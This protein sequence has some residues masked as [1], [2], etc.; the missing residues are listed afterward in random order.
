MTPDKNKIAADCLKRGTE[1][2]AREQFDYAVEMFTQSMK[3][4]PDN[5]L[6]RQSLRG[7][8]KK[9]YKENGSGARMAGMKLMKTRT[10]LKKSQMT[11]DW[12]GVDAVAEEGLKIN[13]W[14]SALN[15]AVGEACQNLGFNNVALFGYECALEADPKNKDLLRTYARMQEERGNYPTAIAAWQ[16]LLKIDELDSE[17]RSK[18][19]QLAA[20]SMMK[21]G[22]YEDAQ[23]TQDVKTGYD[24]DRPG[25]KG[26]K[27]AGEEV[28]DGPGMSLEADLERAVRKEPENKDNYL[29]LA[30]FLKRENRLEEA[31]ENLKKALDLTGGSDNTIREQLED[32][33]LDQLRNNQH[34]AREA[35][36]ADPNDE[37]ARKNS[38]ALA[39]ELLKREIEVL[40]SRVE[41]YP[42]NARF[43]FELAKNHKR[44]QAYGPAIK[45][46]QQ[47]VADTR[48]ACDVL[49][50]LGECFYEDKK[51]PL[52]LRQFEKAAD[53]VDPQ[54]QVDLFK[55]IHYA[56]GRLYQ[57]AGKRVEAENHFQE[58]LGVDYDYRDT[59]KRLEKLQ[60]ADDESADE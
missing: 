8:T 44:M 23:S 31:A 47:A 12:K 11:K 36:K 49:V 50:V 56:L 34:V 58:V 13:P 52:A 24:Y 29:K 9:M 4:V 10:R 28:A 16:K 32:I 3:L 48:I 7:T 6:F 26:R 53:L 20:S 1:A 30:D 39:R 17:A 27:P 60:A 40:S 35:A 22:N 21:T 18:V 15:A 5:V 55:K 37:A 41:R 25:N 45:L 33:E 46:L 57:S 42:K 43:K 19:T 2:L 14:D 51:K 59:L 54:E 38:V